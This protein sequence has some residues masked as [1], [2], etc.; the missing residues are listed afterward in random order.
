MCGKKIDH[1]KKPLIY[2][3]EP[4]EKITHPWVAAVYRKINDTYE[5]VCGAS[6][7]NQRVVVTG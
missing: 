6:I 4:N 5:N 1:D 3:A 7:L 2:G